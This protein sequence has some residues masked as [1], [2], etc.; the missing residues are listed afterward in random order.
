MTDEERI[1]EST[2]DHHVLRLPGMHEMEKM[3]DPLHTSSEEL[4]L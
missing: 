1:K 4:L 2:Q 3:L